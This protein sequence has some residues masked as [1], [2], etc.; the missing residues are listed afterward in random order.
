MM[1]VKTVQTNKSIYKKKKKIE[2]GLLMMMM[3]PTHLLSSDPVHV[4]FLEWKSKEN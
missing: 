4:T 3:N 1:M 2:T